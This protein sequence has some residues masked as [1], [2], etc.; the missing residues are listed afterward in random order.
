MW[1]A[2]G[3]VLGAA[4][5]LTIGRAAGGGEP[6]TEAVPTTTTRP[7]PVWF[8]PQ[9]IVLGPAAIVPESLRVLH[10]GVELAY[11]LEP[12]TPASRGPEDAVE[13]AVFPDW[14]TLLTDEGPIAGRSMP[15]T[16]EVLFEVPAG[17]TADRIRGVRLDSSWLLAPIRVPFRPGLEDRTRHEIAPGVTAEVALVQD[18]AGGALV[19]VDL[20]AADPFVADDLAVQG[21]GAGWRPSTP[22]VSGTTRWSLLYLRGDLPD[23][24]PMEITGA[25]WMPRTHSIPLDLGAILDG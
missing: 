13:T 2:G 9:E 8:E 1:A 10:S 16:R 19:V 15:W 22:N 25:A 5:T 18:Q 6:P 4:A 20:A 11:R 17:F 14:W 7:A 23:P 21:T 24:I 12:I 3:I